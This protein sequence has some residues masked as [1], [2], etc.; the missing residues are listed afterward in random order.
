[1]LQAKAAVAA[2]ILTLLRRVDLAPSRIHRLYLAGGFGMHVVVGNAIGCG[3]LPG[4]SP[5]L[6][7]VVGN[8]SLAGAYLALIDANVV[9]ELTRVGRTIDVVELNLDPGFESCYIDQLSL[10]PVS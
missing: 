8:T 9:A 3:M 1:L 4:V 2:G 5:E 10:S 7:Q 6:V